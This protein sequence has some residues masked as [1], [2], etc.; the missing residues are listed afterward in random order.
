MS[1]NK[2]QKFADLKLF[3]NVFD[4][5]A[6]FRKWLAADSRTAGGLTL[7]LACGKGEYT[8]ALAT[9]RPQQL[10]V[11]LDLKGARLWAPARIARE[12]NLSNVAFLRTRIEQIGHFFRNGEIREIWITFPDPYRKPSKQQKRLTSPR[13]LELY[14][15]LLQPHHRLH[16]KTDHAGLYE[17]SR[18]SI[19]GVKGTIHKQY[20]DLHA[21]EDENDSLS[22]LTTYERRHLQAGKA[23]KYIC[24]SLDS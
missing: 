7:E 2:T 6:E 4:R 1:R 15:P 14:R 24:F 23:I 22:I 11:G 21:A 9:H 19:L 16:L 17:F 8:L 10:F 13:F 3:E 5:A 18:A 20:H 12:R